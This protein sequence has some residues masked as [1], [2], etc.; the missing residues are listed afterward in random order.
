MNIGVKVM[1]KQ[2][3]NTLGATSTE[4]NSINKLMIDFEVGAIEVLEFW[5]NDSRY[6]NSNN[7]IYAIYRLVIESLNL[8]ES[9]LSLYCNGVYS[10]LMYNNSIVNSK[11]ELIR[12]IDRV[13]EFE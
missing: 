9:E 12:E 6:F 2:F 1:E 13:T 7:F 4:Y 8:Q 10:K 11:V 5:N 3:I